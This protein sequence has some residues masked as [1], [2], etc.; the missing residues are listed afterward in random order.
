MHCWI[1]G[2]TRLKIH[3]NQTGNVQSNGSFQTRTALNFRMQ[4]SSDSYSTMRGTLTHLHPPR[5]YIRRKY[6][7]LHK[8]ALSSPRRRP[9]ACANST[10]G[11]CCTNYSQQTCADASSDDDPRLASYWSLQ[12]SEH[13]SSRPDH[14]FAQRVLRSQLGKVTETSYLIVSSGHK[15][16]N[17]DHIT[18][19]TTI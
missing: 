7:S 17:D 12:I 18:L 9:S 4:R 19:K 3:L 5:H 6:S 11:Y 8:T 14:K 1:K 10:F 13:Q 15:L 2:R 16:S